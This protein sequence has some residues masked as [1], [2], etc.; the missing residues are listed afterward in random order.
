MMLK[1]I[2][3]CDKIL[4]TACVVMFVRMHRYMCAHTNVNGS[5]CIRAHMHVRAHTD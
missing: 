1:H 4:Y 5:M 3:Q 2:A